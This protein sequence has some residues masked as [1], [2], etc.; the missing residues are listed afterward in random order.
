[1]GWT[2]SMCE[3][4]WKLHNADREPMEMKNA[5]KETCCFC[6]NTHTSGIYTRFD[7]SKT[8]CHGDC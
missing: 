8:L 4:C 5:P 2:H 3:S 7:P 1:M 6:G